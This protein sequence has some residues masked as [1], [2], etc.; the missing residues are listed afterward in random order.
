MARDLFFGDSA[1]RRKY[2]S[3]SKNQKVQKR[4]AKAPLAALVNPMEGQEH[5]MND[6][7]SF[8][9]AAQSTVHDESGVGR[10]GRVLPSHA[11]IESPV[12]GGRGG[13]RTR[14]VLP[15]RS[16]IE[17]HVH[18]G[19]A[20]GIS[21]AVQPIESPLN[22]DFLLTPRR[23]PIGH[24][25]RVHRNLEKEYNGL[26]S[27]MRTQGRHSVPPPAENEIQQPIQ[28]SASHQSQH[29]A[30]RSSSSQQ[31]HRSQQRKNLRDSPAENNNFSQPNRSR[32][33]SN[34]PVANNEDVGNSLQEG[35]PQRTTRKKTTN[36]AV[37]K[38]GKEKVS[39][40]VFKENFC[41]HYRHELINSIGS[42]VRQRDNCPVTYDKFDDMPEQKIARVIQN[43]RD[44]FILDPDDDVAVKAIKDV[45][46]NAYKAYMH[47]LHLAYQKDGGDGFAESDGHL[48]A[49]AHMCAHFTTDE[50]KKNSERGRLAAAAKQLNGI[51]H[52]NGN[53]S[54]T[55][56]EYELVYIMPSSIVLKKMK[57]MKEDEDRGETNDTPEEIFNKVRNAGCSGKRRRKAHPTNYSLYQKKEEEMA[58]LKV[59]MASLEQENKR[60]KKETGPKATKKWL[61]EYLVKVGMLAMELSSEDDAED[62]DEDANMHG[63]QINEHRDAFEGSDM[64]T[65]EE[66]IEAFA[67]EEE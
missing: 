55:S 2:E 42:W 37:A 46:R 11:P 50:F 66:D 18:E 48:E 38:R 31:S 67:D 62:D 36:L 53:K 1:L 28:S 56:I 6:L 52:S 45:M 49:L 54:F 4:G 7:S 25:T 3:T 65:E 14:L 15:S 20:G 32:S 40:A 34:S 19:R 5:Q 60:L 43:F 13:G 59:R 23:S 22:N 58:E 63:S 26:H 51:N 29:N 9:Q 12:H 16:P 30:L 61:N 44:H 41:G 10:T 8:L 21:R 27:P 33:A 24:R 35:Q 57:A 47:K 39:V 64:E 17:S